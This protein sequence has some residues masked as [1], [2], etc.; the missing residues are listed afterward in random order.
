MSRLS[1]GVED[2]FGGIPLKRYPLH[3]HRLCTYYFSI[4]TAADV[5]HSTL[6]LVSSDWVTGQIIQ[7]DGGSAVSRPGVPKEMYL[8]MQQA[9]RAKM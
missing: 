1:A 7:I 6:Y 2:A 3:L 5:A 9:R 4:G 8:A